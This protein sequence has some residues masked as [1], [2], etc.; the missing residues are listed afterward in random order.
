MATAVPIL[1][2]V[3]CQQLL[4][5][6]VI[7][8][9]CSA[10]MYGRTPLRQQTRLWRTGQETVEADD[11]QTTGAAAHAAQVRMRQTTRTCPLPR[12]EP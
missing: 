6:Q 11:E 9:H 3:A 4:C 2:R 8:A 10:W 12:E 5:R 1:D 7:C